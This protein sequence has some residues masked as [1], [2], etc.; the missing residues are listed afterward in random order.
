[1]SPP[2]CFLTFTTSSFISASWNTGD[3]LTVTV[4]LVVADW[5]WTQASETSAIPL[6]RQGILNHHQYD[7]C[8]RDNIKKSNAE[9][10]TILQPFR[11]KSRTCTW[12]P[13]I[14][15]KE[16]LP[17]TTTL[18]D[19]TMMTMRRLPT[20]V[21]QTTWWPPLQTS[22][23]ASYWQI[24]SSTPRTSTSHLLLLLLLLLLVSFS[25]WKDKDI[26]KLARRA[27]DSL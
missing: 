4:V 19:K 26:S 21:H 23:L 6:H 7:H 9:K 15:R 11:I 3:A 18:E 27:R 2:P 22:W 10:E 14:L 17:R 25:H 20:K 16:W 24:S 1:M 13:P 12:W 8:C 5:V